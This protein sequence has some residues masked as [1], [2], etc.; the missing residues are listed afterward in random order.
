MAVKADIGP[1]KHGSQKTQI[2][3]K[4]AQ[5]N[6]W[7]FPTP[8]LGSAFN[9]TKAYCLEMLSWNGGSWGGAVNTVMEVRASVGWGVRAWGRGG[10]STTFVMDSNKKADWLLVLGV[11]WRLLGRQASAVASYKVLSNKK[12]RTNNHWEEKQQICFKVITEQWKLH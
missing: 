5:Q 6:L 11:F 8:K 4:T 10:R 1:L 9:H 12:R 7:Q 3:L 2:F